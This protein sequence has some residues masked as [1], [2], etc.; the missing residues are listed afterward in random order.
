MILLDNKRLE[1]VFESVHPKA[2]CHLSFQ[3]TLRVPDDNKNYP[4]P[5]NMGSFPLHHV[6]DHAD[7]VPESWFKRGGVLLPM[8]QA[9][10]MWIKLA[11]AKTMLR[12][13]PCAVKIAAGKINAVTGDPWSEPLSAEPQDYVVAPSQLWLDGFSVARGQVRQFVA[14]PLGQGHTVEEQLSGAGEYGGLQIVVYPMK[15]SVYQALFE[16]PSTDDGNSG[17]GIRFSIGAPD[18]GLA[19]GGLIRQQIDEDPYGIDVWDQEQGLRCYVHLLNSMQ[20]QQITGEAPPQQPLTAREYAEA[21][22]PWFE[23]YSD[24][25]AL[26]GSEQLAGLASVQARQ[27]MAG[28]ESV[29][30]ANTHNISP[31]RVIRSGQ[32]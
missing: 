18:M 16:K 27:G 25:P 17:G 15:R 7:K 14:M 24:A 13:Y 1:F 28:E 12:R 26:A 3:R 32:F 31:K 20:Y 30:P 5:A 9:E 19:P 21:D 29:T 10:A 2:Q 4:L 22:L 11:S 23:Y 6:D 8:Y